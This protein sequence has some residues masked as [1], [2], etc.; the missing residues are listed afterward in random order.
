MSSAINTRGSRRSFT[1]I[2]TLRGASPNSAE[3]AWSDRQGTGP[4]A[5]PSR[6]SAG[7]R[8]SATRQLAI[9]RRG[10]GNHRP[11]PSW[12]RTSQISTGAREKGALTHR[13]PQ[14]AGH[15][16]A[17]ITS[18]NSSRAGVASRVTGSDQR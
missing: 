18:A 17:S 1:T 12:R 13:Y 3:N 14:F 16:Q 5:S 11:P 8:P 2:A 6:K 15:Q 4:C 9:R 7:W 10:R